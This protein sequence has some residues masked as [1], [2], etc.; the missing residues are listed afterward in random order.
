MKINDI[1]K[2]DRVRLRSGQYGIMIDDA[3]G[4][5]RD[6]HVEGEFP[7]AGRVH[8]TDII[9]VLIGNVWQSIDHTSSFAEELVP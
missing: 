2:G 4:D 9:A 6:V 1:K 8:I 5:I 3:Q 7:Q